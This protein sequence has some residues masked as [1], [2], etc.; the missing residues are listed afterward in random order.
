MDR[1][2]RSG[3][4]RFV[5]CWTMWAGTISHTGAQVATVVSFDN[6]DGS[7]FQSNM[8]MS[9]S[10][11]CQELNRAF[12]EKR[13]PMLPQ[14]TPVA[15]ERIRALWS[16]APF[17]V[18]AVRLTGNLLSLPGGGFQFRNIPLV[19][20]DEN[21]SDRQE[22]GV[23][24]MDNEGLIDDFSFGLELHR[25]EQL[26]SAGKDEVDSIRRRRIL[27]F[28]EDFRTAYNRKDINLLENTFSENALIIM[29]KVIRPKP[30]GEGINYLSGLGKERVELI[31]MSKKEYMSQLR[32]S[33]ARNQFID[34]R[35]TDMN[36]TRHPAYKTIYGVSLRQAWR[37]STYADDGYLFVMIDF[38]DDSRPII[39]VRAWQ[40]QKFTPKSD[41]IQL[42]E[43]IIFK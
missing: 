42:G 43:F 18:S 17:R 40:P 19:L 22:S 4:I 38:E 5:L 36:I 21:G 23:F 11:V 20:R 28:L 33:F 10:A 27:D 2:L 39:H 16:T 1:S 13:Q 35:F 12:A 24:N 41:V 29:G 34:V 9:I 31:R 7:L 8:E 32:L 30:S 37:S 25:W 3:L 26:L 14:V 15:R 6:R